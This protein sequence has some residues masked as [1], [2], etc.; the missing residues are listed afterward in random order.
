M[1]LSDEG[2][3]IV[4]IILEEL[5]KGFRV[6][7]AE[8]SLKD[9]EERSRVRPQNIGMAFYDYIA[10]PLLKKGIKAEKRGKPVAIRLTTA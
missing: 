2:A 3:K 8:F 5:E 9:L 6:L 4:K 7:P 1:R 10:P